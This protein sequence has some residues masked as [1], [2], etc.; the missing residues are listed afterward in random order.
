MN[1]EY[2]TTSSLCA[3]NSCTYFDIVIYFFTVM[4]KGVLLICTTK[5]MEAGPQN[6]ERIWPDVENWKVYGPRTP[7]CS[8]P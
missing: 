3:W 4:L 6:K 1:K 2:G 5:D 7:T 8:W